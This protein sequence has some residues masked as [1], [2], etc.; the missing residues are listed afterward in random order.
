MY[1]RHITG[2]EGESD[3]VKF[4]RKN[5]YEILETNFSCKQGEID[6]IAKDTSSDEVVFVEVK[7]RLNRNYGDAIDAVDFKKQRHII[8]AAKFYIYINNF[9]NCFIRFDIITIYKNKLRHYKNCE[10]KT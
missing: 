2:K 4:L 3:A 5:D 10:F 9:E 7:T 6:I 8:A 1:E